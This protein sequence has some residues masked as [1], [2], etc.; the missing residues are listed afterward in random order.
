MFDLKK[1]KSLTAELKVLYVEDDKSISNSMIRYLS[2]F[3][4][5][6]VYSPNGQDGLRKYKEDKFDMVI[7]DL[8]MPKM[9]GIDM[10]KEIKETDDLQVVIITSAHGDS[11]YLQEA[12]KMGVDGY[13]IKPFDFDQ[14][15]NE[16]YKIVQKLNTY[17]ENELYK[18][19]LKDIVEAKTAELNELMNYH[20]KNYE[21]TLYSMIKMIEQRD[22]YTAGHSKRVAEYSKCIAEQ[23]G[24]SK[25][26]CTLMHQAGILHD[27]GKIA[28]PDA[29]LLK[30]KSLNDIE[31][32]L[33]QEHVEV[34]YKLLHSIP[35]FERLSEI[36][37]S[38]HERYDGGGYPQGLKADEISPLAR[39]MIVAD[40]FDAMT[41]NRVYKARKT[42]PEALKELEDLKMKQFHPEV[43]DAAK[44]AL[45]DVI[46]D[47]NIS[48][49]PNSKLEEERFAYF[50]KDTISEA[51]NHNYL[52]VVL[53][54]NSF[55]LSL[56]YMKII[57]LKQFSKYNKKYGWKAGD[58]MLG[59]IGNTLCSELPNA[60]VFRIFGDDF[61]LICKH[62]LEFSQIQKELDEIV[63]D[64]FNYTIKNID[65]TKTP[66]NKITQI[67]K[68]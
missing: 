15:N 55:D 40:A 8:S 24:Y 32:K 6:V 37:R 21:K 2:K 19:H 66:I 41:T 44:I 58:K 12:I 62:T 67:A 1:L 14:L 35:M 34:S 11:E 7:T 4:K 39:I 43:V 48:Q 60:L 17:K 16:I 64:K 54:K 38:H 42:I 61:A 33:I 46:I 26:E 27:V 59:L 3:F 68:A 49:L 47:E 9:N 65:L 52:D 30:P 10:I 18:K 22:T 23:M 28:T 29:V 57:S 5:L 36:V 50:Y 51:Y 25:E 63:K 45:K 13:I 31:Y 20:N 56:K 53:M